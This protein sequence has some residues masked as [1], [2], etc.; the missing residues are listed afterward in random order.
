[1]APE[2][3]PLSSDKLTS[4]QTF[5]NSDANSDVALVDSNYASQNKLAPG[6]TVSIGGTTGTSTSFKVIGV[7]ADRPAPPRA[8]STSRSPGRRP[9]RPVRAAA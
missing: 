5:S 7:V 1:M 9:W 6:S 4:G 3:G 2:V 8:T